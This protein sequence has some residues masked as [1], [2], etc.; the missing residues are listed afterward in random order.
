MKIKT[1]IVSAAVVAS[2][3]AVSCQKE[4]SVYELQDPVMV[5]QKYTVVKYEIDGV[6]YEH[7]CRSKT[8]FNDLVLRLLAIA[9]EGRSVTIF[10]DNPTRVATKEV[11]QY[12]A[13]TE[14]EAQDW[15]DKMHDLGYHVSFYFDKG[16]GVY[17]CT[18]YN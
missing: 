5:Q 3:L 6:A 11:I 7:L 4:D 17:V 2:L 10:S 13:S 1:L 12:H 16:L 9:K 15:C 18:A 14:A 8:D